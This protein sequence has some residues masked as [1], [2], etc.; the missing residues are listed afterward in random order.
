MSNQQF[1]QRCSCP[2][3][4]SSFDVKTK[5]LARFHCHCLICQKLYQKP[6]ADFNVMLSH[7][8]TLNDSSNIAF[9]R[10]R[11]PPALRRGTCKKCKHPV[12]GFLRLAPFIELA[13]VASSN[14]HDA[15]ELPAPQAHIFY[16]RRSADINDNLPKH[17]GYLKSEWAV[18]AGITRGLFTKFSKHS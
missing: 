13:F 5:P 14:Y 9:D 17:E 6:S 8:V 3:G 16:H 12:I 10:Y 4:A 7:K 15:S 2:C 18:T 1:Q 11:L